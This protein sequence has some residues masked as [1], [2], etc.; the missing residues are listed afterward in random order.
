MREASGTV[1]RVALLNPRRRFTAA[2][3]LMLLVEA[4]AEVG[5]LWLDG[6]M[7]KI[8]ILEPV[9]HLEP[10]LKGGAR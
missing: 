1:D 3:C 2:E 5:E 6:L 4:R 7:S 10:S 8:L 9:R